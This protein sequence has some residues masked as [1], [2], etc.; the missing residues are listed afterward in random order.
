MNSGEFGDSGAWKQL[1]EHIKFAHPFL[2]ISSLTDTPSPQGVL[3][4]SGVS[5]L[6]QTVSK[7]DES[8]IMMI[9]CCEV[10]QRQPI[11]NETPP[12]LEED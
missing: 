12:M 6:S 3:W 9:C 1:N 7:H 10:E 5:V 11:L 8:K 4:N 2:C